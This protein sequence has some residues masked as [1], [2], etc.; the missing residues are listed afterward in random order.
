[1][2]VARDKFHAEARAK[3]GGETLSSWVAAHPGYHLWAHYDGLECCVACGAARK[4]GPQRPCPGIVAI[5]L[6]DLP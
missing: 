3:L 5:S 2:T 4:R 6:R 1:M